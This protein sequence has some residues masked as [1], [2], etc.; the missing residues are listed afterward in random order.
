MIKAVIFDLDNTLYDYDKCHEIAMEK[1]EEYACKRYLL[2]HAKFTD[3]FKAARDEVKERLESTASAHNRMLYMQL[4]LEKIDRKPLD[5]ALELYNTY[6][7]E[8]LDNI[9]L[10]G[11]VRPLMEWLKNK[12]IRI[13]ILTDLTANIQHRKLYKLDLKDYIDV[14]VTSEE[15]GQE[16]PSKTIFEIAL[17]KLCLSPSEV[18]M[19][20]DSTSKDIVGSEKVGINALLFKKELKDDIEDKLKSIIKGEVF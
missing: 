12:G 18:I 6:W 13:A 19:V 10:F 8:F 3:A 5:G 15:A 14:L 1:V 2:S 9:R 17:N 11:Y 7:D 4:F 20:G 16:K